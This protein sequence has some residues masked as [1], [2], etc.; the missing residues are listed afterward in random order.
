MQHHPQAYRLIANLLA[1]W[2]KEG[3]AVGVETQL[4]LRE[5]TQKLPND[6]HIP[7][8]KTLLADRKSVV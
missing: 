4:Q 7:N 1:A 6:I 8:L 3:F 2:E 5:L